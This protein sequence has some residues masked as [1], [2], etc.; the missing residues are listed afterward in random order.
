MSYD[1]PCYEHTCSAQQPLKIYMATKYHLQNP[2][3]LPAF[4]VVPTSATLTSGNY[5]AL[6]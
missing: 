5:T 6:L 1:I 2:S 4:F 3:E